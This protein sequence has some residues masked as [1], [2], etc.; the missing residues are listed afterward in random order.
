MSSAI[1][2]AKEAADP[3]VAG[4]DVGCLD[5]GDLINL[6]LQR[7]EVMYDLPRAG[8]VIRA[9]GGGDMAPMEA[10][11]DRLG[12]RWHGARQGLFMRNTVKLRLCCVT[13]HRKEW[14][15]S[16]AAMLSLTCFWRGICKR[17]LC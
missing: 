7:S 8:Q 14:P 4:L 2:I 13:L 6:I 9:W 16:V 1:N 15:T 17:M 5:R 10:E 11:I 12:G 3:V